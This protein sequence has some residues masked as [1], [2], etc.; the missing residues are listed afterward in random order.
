MNEQP[1]P[2][3]PSADSSLLPIDSVWIPDDEEAFV[4][5]SVLEPASEPDSVVVTLKSG[6][7][8]RPYPT[9]RC[10][11]GSPTNPTANG[12][13]IRPFPRQSDRVR[14]FSRH[15]RPPLSQR[16]ERTPQSQ[17]ALLQVL[18]LRMLST[19]NARVTLVYFS[20]IRPTPASSSSPSIRIDH[21]PSTLLKLSKVR[22]LGL[23]ST[24]NRQLTN[25]NF[26]LQEQTTR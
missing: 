16:S 4:S 11:V 18:H 24:Q 1:I 6:A 21:S 9:R 10:S 8:V 2:P 17:D 12:G 26:R 13:E 25:P 15:C 3:W 7:Y 19:R 5:T 22:S 23:S 14:W 20:R